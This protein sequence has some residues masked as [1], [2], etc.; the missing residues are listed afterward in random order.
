MAGAL[1]LL[2]ETT[3]PS[4]SKDPICV[5]AN[6]IA[7]AIRAVKGAVVPDVDAI[8]LRNMVAGNSVYHARGVDFDSPTEAD[9]V[10]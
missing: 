2:S 9:G 3:L 4:T 10:S 8:A 5:K 6:A 7:N 1:F